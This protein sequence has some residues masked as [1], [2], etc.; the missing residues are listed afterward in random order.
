MNQ[1]TERP[2]GNT[3]QE[4]NGNGGWGRRR[5]IQ[6][7]GKTLDAHWDASNDLGNETLLSGDS[8]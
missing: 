7:R 8:G 1:N 3:C 4:V 6:C 2:G 5:R